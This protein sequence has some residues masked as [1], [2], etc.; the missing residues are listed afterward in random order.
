[1][2]SKNTRLDLKILWQ[3][4]ETGGNGFK[5]SIDQSLLLDHINLNSAC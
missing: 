2:K 3:T 1:M 5:Q 4:M